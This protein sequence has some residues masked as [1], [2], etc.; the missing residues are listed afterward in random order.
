M[1]IKIK[2][3]FKFID[4]IIDLYDNDINIINETNVM[5]DGKKIGTI[6][7]KLFYL[8]IIQNIEKFFENF[9]AIKNKKN[10]AVFVD[11]IFY[12]FIDA[13]HNSLFLE[14]KIEITKDK[15]KLSYHFNNKMIYIELIKKNWNL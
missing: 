6:F 4:K 15:S 1:E 5:R 13:I 9:V 11:N 7:S 12:S 3:N 2:K 8:D 14:S 10:F